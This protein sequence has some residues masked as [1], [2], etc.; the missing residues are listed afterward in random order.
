[1][2]QNKFYIIHNNIFKNDVFDK[3]NRIYYNNKGY[4]LI[5]GSINIKYI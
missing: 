4:V 5:V 1:M 2:T 3:N